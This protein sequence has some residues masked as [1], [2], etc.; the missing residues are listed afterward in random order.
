MLYA[1]HFFSA[2]YVF[3]SS[4]LEPRVS[5]A[6]GREG[7]REYEKLKHSRRRHTE[8]LHH[9]FCEQMMFLARLPIDDDDD[10]AILFIHRVA[11]HMSNIPNV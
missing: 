6:T 3:F 10:A 7:E 11:T 2:A 8:K 9:A 4:I 5:K 1:T